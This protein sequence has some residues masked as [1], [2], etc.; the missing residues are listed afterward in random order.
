M[1]VRVNDA[2]LDIN[3][4]FSSFNNSVDLNESDQIAFVANLTLGGR[5]VYVATAG[6]WSQYAIQGSDGLGEIEFFQSS[7]EQ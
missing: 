7:A 3:S 1:T 6:G 4:P 2:T 5:G